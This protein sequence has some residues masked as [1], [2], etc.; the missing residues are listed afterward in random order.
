MLWHEEIFYPIVVH[1]VGDSRV[2]YAW[3]RGR[4]FH[5]QICRIFCD[6]C[7]EVGRLFAHF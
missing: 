7:L 3:G 4:L 1:V 2:E 5:E 6:I